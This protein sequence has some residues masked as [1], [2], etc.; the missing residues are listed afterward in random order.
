[1][2]N[3]LLLVLIFSALSVINLLYS[4]QKLEA[5]DAHRC[6]QFVY[7]DIAQKAFESDKEKYYWMDR[8]HDGQACT[9]LPK[10]LHADGNI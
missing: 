6:D 5:M 10:S 9:N 4:K 2:K 8:N 1:M 3:I 7:Q